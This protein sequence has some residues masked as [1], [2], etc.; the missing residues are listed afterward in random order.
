MSVFYNTNAANKG[1]LF[2]EPSK[3]IMI[4]RSGTNEY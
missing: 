1:N 4:D 3:T 2:I